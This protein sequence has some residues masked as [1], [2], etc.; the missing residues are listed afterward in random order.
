[1]ACKMYFD[2]Y[3]HDIDDLEDYN[4]M[5]ARKVLQDAKDYADETIRIIN[6]KTDNSTVGDT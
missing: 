5:K 6:K 3:R 2:T 4:M 1:M